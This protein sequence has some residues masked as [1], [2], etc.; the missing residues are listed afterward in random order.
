MEIPVSGPEFQ[1]FIFGKRTSGLRMDFL[2]RT[3]PWRRSQKHSAFKTIVGSTQVPISGL[4]ADS[5]TSS[6]ETTFWLWWDKI[7]VIPQRCPGFWGRAIT[8]FRWDGPMDTTAMDSRRTMGQGGS[9]LKLSFRNRR[10]V[11]R[12]PMVS[13]S[14][15]LL[16]ETAI[17]EGY[18]DA[19]ENETIRALIMAGATKMEFLGDWD[20]TTTRPLD[21]HYGA[22][23]LNIFR[24]HQILT[25]G[26]Q[27][28]SDV[29]DAPLL[30]WDFRETTS[31]N[32]YFFEVPADKV[33]AELSAV[34]VWN[35]I[36]TDAPGSGFYPQPQTLDNLD[37]KL[38]SAQGF[39]LDAELDASLS[40]ADNVEHIYLNALGNG[41]LLGPGS[42]CVRSGLADRRCRL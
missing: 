21:D 3:R 35:R 5:T 9:S 15:A 40:P 41:N 17:D 7:T 29:M 42:V 13:A 30:G 22:G 1:T 38:H 26:Q 32:P 14:A 6:I 11:G 25:S 19:E 31:D 37:L 23:E 33:M 8:F 39:M 16:L 10:L 34:L 12:S 28:A 24:S 20:R 36:V 2:K 4:C 18:G 27:V